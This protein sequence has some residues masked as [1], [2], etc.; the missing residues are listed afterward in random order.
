MFVKYETYFSSKNSA[1]EN[2]SLSK[3]KRK[4]HLFTTDIRGLLEFFTGGANQLN[5]FFQHFYIVLSVLL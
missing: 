4:I 5:Q 1:A 3:I 2:V